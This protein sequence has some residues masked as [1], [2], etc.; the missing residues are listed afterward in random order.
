MKKRGNILYVPDEKTIREHIKKCGCYNGAQPPDAVELE[1][2]LIRSQDAIHAVAK[3]NRQ[4]AMQKINDVFSPH[5]EYKAYACNKCGYVSKD[6]KVFRKHFGPRNPYQCQQATD[7]SSGKVNVYEG[8]YGITCPEHFLN[9]VLEGN[10]TRPNK[11]PRINRRHQMPNRAASTTADMNNTTNSPQEQQRAP[12]AA[13]LRSTPFQP[14]LTTSSTTLTRVMEGTPINELKVNS[15]ARISLALSPFV[16]PSSTNAIDCGNIAFVKKHLPLV[17]KLIDSMEMDR[18]STPELFFRQLV[19]KTSTTQLQ[20]DHEA[21][22]VVQLAG[23]QW[24]KNAANFDVLHI[25]AGHRG[26]LFTVSEPE[27]PDAETMVSGR[28]FVQSQK[29]DKIVT[30]WNH[31]IHFI[32]RHNPSMI[33]DQ[34]GKAREIY[35]KKMED[36]EKERDALADAASEI[37]ETNIIFG[38]ILA[39]VFEKPRTVNGMNTLD[40]FLVARSILTPQ[41]SRLKFLAGGGIGEYLYDRQLFALLQY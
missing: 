10:F 13:T 29:V 39:A 27:A 32:C 35:Y 20:G 31:F 19:S 9:E 18:A 34:L 2:E 30:E 38:I 17:A 41:N 6:K 1:R 36:H 11:R 3:S 7:A 26:R 24:L 5:T 28:T 33:D 14:I 40:Y 8:K 25:S 21:L 22:K 12:T 4:I 37:V 15:E 23:S 16:D